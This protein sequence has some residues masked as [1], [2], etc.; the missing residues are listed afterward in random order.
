MKL[1]DKLA[2]ISARF[3]NRKLVNFFID[4]GARD[5]NEIA[6]RACSNGYKDIVDDIIDKCNN[7]QYVFY[8][9]DFDSMILF[10]KEAGHQELAT[11]LKKKYCRL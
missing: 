3:G 11:Y 7:S 9:L 8:I 10:A 2:C 6:F 4:R 5:F 1:F